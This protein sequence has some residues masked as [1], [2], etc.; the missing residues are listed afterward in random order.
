MKKT[1]IWIVIGS[2]T[3]SIVGLAAKTTNKQFKS[4]VRGA[5]MTGRNQIGTADDLVDFTTTALNHD[6]VFLCKS[7]GSGGAVTPLASLCTSAST[8]AKKV[9]Y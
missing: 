2:I 5:F 3:L 8:S 7:V 1:Q 9:Y 6:Q 4:V